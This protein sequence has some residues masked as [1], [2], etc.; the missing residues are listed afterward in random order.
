MKHEKTAI[1]ER[2]S[3]I[4]NIINDIHSIVSGSNVKWRYSNK[5][6]DCVRNLLVEECFD[7]EE[8]DSYIYYELIDDNRPS[9]YATEY[10]YRFPATFLAAGDEWIKLIVENALLRKKLGLVSPRINSC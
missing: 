10:S 6:F 1:D 5:T 8:S 4:V 2:V 3:E 7:Y 9:K